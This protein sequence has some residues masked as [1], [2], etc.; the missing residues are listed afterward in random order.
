VN[1]IR[2]L[3]TVPHLKSTASPYRETMAIVKYLSQRDFQLTVCSLRVDGF[4]E[5]APFMKEAGVPYFVARF[6]PRGKWMR[7]VVQSLRDQTVI[8]QR[9]PFDIQHSLDFTSSPF[10][11]WMARWKSRRFMFSQ[12][13]R[14]EGGRTWLLRMKIGVSDRIIAIS[15][16]VSEFMA[17]QG[18]SSAKIRKIYNGI[19]LQGI[20]AGA[21]DGKPARTIL[22]VGHLE[23][24]KRHEDAIHTLAQ[25]SK[26]LPGLRLRIAGDVHDQTYS[27][28]L[29]QLSQ[30][31]GVKEQVEFLGPRTDIANL[32]RQSSI[33]FHCAESEAFGWVVLEAMAY[34]LPVIASTSEGPSELIRNNKDGYLVPIGDVAGYA[35]IAAELLKDSALAKRIAA[36]AQERVREK[37]TAISMVHQTEEVYR[38]LAAMN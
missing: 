30:T 3:L 2:I 13:N 5:V 33:L 20:T 14:N 6:R 23:R 16:N 24:R 37:F 10:E 11:G 8:E 21:S 26:E 29:L 36:S 9:G 38:E 32:M 22:C 4:E 35:R 7:H 19:D 15:D 27:A 17:S 25:L 18:A 12:R 34:G 28:E 1:R 31:L